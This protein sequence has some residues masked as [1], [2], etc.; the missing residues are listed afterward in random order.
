MEFLP[1]LGLNGAPLSLA[2]RPAQLMIMHKCKRL[3]GWS[4]VRNL[5]F[6]IV[7][8]WVVKLQ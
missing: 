4:T 7:G 3:N 6:S 5:T 1:I 2:Q 8:L